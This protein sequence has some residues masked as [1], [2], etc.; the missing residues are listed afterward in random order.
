M[1][2]VIAAFA[3]FVVF[4]ATLGLLINLSISGIEQPGAP[5]PMENPF[6]RHFNSIAIFSL[7][8]GL[9]LLIGGIFTSKYRNWA[10]LLVIISAIVLVIVTWVLMVLISFDLAGE[11][12]VVDLWP[13]IIGIFWSAPA[14]LLTWYLNKKDVKKYFR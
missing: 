10:R 2:V 4:G 5:P 1:G 9:S 6:Y 13:Y 7:I 3:G 12:D 8:I 14:I 11:S